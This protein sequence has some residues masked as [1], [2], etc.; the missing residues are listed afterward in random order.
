MGKSEIQPI[1]TG[2]LLM[3]TILAVSAHPDDETLF[4]G[5]TLAMWSD[6][7]HDVYILETTRGEGGEA[8]DPPLAAPETLGVVRENEA[9]AASAALGVKDIFFLPF[10]DPKMEIGGTARPID[11]SLETFSKAVGEYIASLAPDLVLT[12]G[13]NG[14]YGHPQHVYTN[15]AVIHALQNSRGTI[16]VLTWQAWY[17]PSRYARILNVADRADFVCNM[18]PWRE[19]KVTAA[20]C[21]KTQHAM[22][23][24]NSGLARVGD[25][26]W[27]TESF[28][29]LKGSLPE[30]VRMPC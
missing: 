16:A 21:H 7:G 20:L 17:E 22:F 4:A 25:M 28:R 12:H 5:A 9:R 8:G 27:D 23:L 26:I 10:V 1:S 19:T 3:A 29:L 18:A 11:V 30:D 2:G 13:T 6:Q 24:R 14:E 15:R